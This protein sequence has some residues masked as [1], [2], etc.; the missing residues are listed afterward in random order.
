M[1][2]RGAGLDRA[3]RTHG[4]KVVAIAAITPL[5][6]SLSAWAAGSTQMPYGS[7][8]AVSLLRLVRIV[9]VL[10]LID[11]GLMSVT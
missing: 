5:P 2:G 11:L 7:F 4:I 8:L 3:L 1:T 6:Y 10:Y 9:G